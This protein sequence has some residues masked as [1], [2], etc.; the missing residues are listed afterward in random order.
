MTIP[1][2][3]FC[4]SDGDF[5]TGKERDDKTW[6]EIVLPDFEG[7]KVLVAAGAFYGDVVRMLAR[8]NCTRAISIE[9]ADFI[10]FTG[11]ADVDPKLYGQAALLST[12]YYPPRDREEVAIYHKARELEK[13]MYGICRGAQFLHVMNGGELWQ[14]VNNHGGEDHFIYDCEEDLYVIANS[15]HHQMLKYQP[16][17]EIVALCSEQ[18]ATLF[19]DATMTI[20]LK[21]EGSNSDTEVEIEA[22]TYPETL[23]HFVQG[24]PE[25]SNEQYTSWCLSKLYDFLIM[26]EDMTKV[27]EFKDNARKEA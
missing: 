4:M 26:C 2:K 23:C 12:S 19:Q 11:G 18:T 17:L 9:E 14:H 25:V 6:D 21:K 7:K 8:A 3:D 5:A 22:G 15:Y 1:T 24:H 16:T 10:V 20:D 13:P 27:D